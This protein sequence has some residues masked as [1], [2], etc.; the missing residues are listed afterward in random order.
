MG[1]ERTAGK[2]F[3]SSYISMRM[4]VWICREKRGRG[5]YIAIIEEEEK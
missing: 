1:F 2:A 3:L 4:Y 5:K